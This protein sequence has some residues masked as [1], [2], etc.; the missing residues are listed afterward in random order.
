[1]L[2]NTMVL[3]WLCVRWFIF[4]VLPQWNNPMM[5]ASRCSPLPPSHVKRPPSE[6]FL[7]SYFIEA[8]QHY[9]WICNFHVRHTPSTTQLKAAKNILSATAALE[10]K[11]LGSWPQPFGCPLF[12]STVHI[13]WPQPN[14]QTYVHVHTYTHTHT[15][16]FASNI[17]S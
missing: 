11:N 17:S 9:R 3:D 8:F 1:M 2:T 16:S 6:W 13:A 7:A 5:R 10:L 14:A 15:L 4:S 12:Q